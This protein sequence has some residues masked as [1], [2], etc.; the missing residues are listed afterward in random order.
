[1]WAWLGALGIITQ[2]GG[3]APARLRRLPACRMAE[4]FASSMCTCLRCDKAAVKHPSL[5]THSPLC[6]LQYMTQRNRWGRIERALQLW[7]Q[8]QADR[9]VP[10]LCS[11]QASTEQAAAAASHATAATVR[12]L[13]RVHVITHEEVGALV[14]GGVVG[15]VGALVVGGVVGGVGWGGMGG[16][17][18]EGGVVG[19][20]VGRG[21]GACAGCNSVEG[22]C[23]ASCYT[24]LILP[25]SLRFPCA[26]NAGAEQVGGACRHGARAARSPAATQG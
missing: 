21:G 12:Q 25:L 14:V 26:V 10:L 8:R 9:I 16:W 3:A 6:T 13:E 19:G 11:M 20:W 23:P 15:G 4:L 1:M 17:V 24:W 18:E 7:N 22:G 2:V 5:P